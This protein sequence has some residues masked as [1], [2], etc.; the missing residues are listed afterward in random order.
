MKATIFGLAVLSLAVLP[1]HARRF[2][3]GPLE[4]IV[5]PVKVPEAGQYKLLDIKDKQTDAAPLYEKAVQAM[6]SGRVQDKQVRAWLELPPAQLPR[7]E[8]EAMIQQHMESLRLVFQAA[9]CETCNWPAWK[10]GMEVPDL[11]EYRRLTFLLELW[12]RL[13]IANGGNDGAL[14]AMQTGFGM[15]RHLGQAPTAVQG[16]VGISVAGVM[17]RDIEFFIQGKDAPNLYHALANL[18]RPLVDL[19]PALDNEMAGLKDQNFLLRKQM[20]KQ[21]KPAH[22]RMRVIANRMGT[23]LNAL[24]CAEAIRS[25]AATHDG[26]L[27]EKLTDIGTL[28]LPMDL[29]NDQAFGYQPTS[30][31]AVLQTEVPAGGDAGDIVRYRIVVKK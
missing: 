11:S 6:P 1:A 20:E 3:D 17:C 12:A 10:A 4:L 28:E 25:Y 8:V 23:N 14:L 21:L 19:Q 16:M 22:D 5:D 2:A 24:Q 9:R 13:E 7:Q 27:P 31:G 30:T 29:M 26:G 15:A 18:P